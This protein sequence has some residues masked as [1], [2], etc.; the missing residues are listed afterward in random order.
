MNKKY[1][2]II[3]TAVMLSFMGGATAQSHYY[4]LVGDTVDGRSPIYYY[5]WWPNVD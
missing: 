4:H 2:T 5:D 3:I 1:K